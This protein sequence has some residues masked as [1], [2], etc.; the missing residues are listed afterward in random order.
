MEGKGT[1]LPYREQIETTPGVDLSGVQVYIGGAAA[2]ACEAMGMQAYT[3]G[4]KI[5]FRGYPCL[6]VARH[7][8]TH[9]V[10]QRQGV[11]LP[12]GVGKKGDAYEQEAEEVA[13]RAASGKPA[14]DLVSKRGSAEAAEGE[15]VQ[16][17]IAAKLDTKGRIRISD[18]WNAVVVQANA[19]GSQEFYALPSLIPAA[20]AK[21]AGVTS[22]IRLTE[23]RKSMGVYQMYGSARKKGQTFHEQHRDVHKQHGKNPLTMRVR[24]A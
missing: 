4:D 14:H 23:A 6:E 7:E 10:Q 18:D 9:V 3:Q 13:K 2:E 20:S 22:S 19:A 12:G 8:A 1:A 24:K 5:A 11:S 15:D 16:A 17:Y 21:L